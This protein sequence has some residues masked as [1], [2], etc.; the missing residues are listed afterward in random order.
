VDVVEGQAM[1]AAAR[2]HGKVVQVGTQRRSTPHL[3]E[4]K[5]TIIKEG[6]LGRVAHVEIYCYYHMRARTNPPDTNPPEH[7][8][9]EMWTGPA[10]LRPYNELVHPRRWRAFTEYGNGIMGDMCIHML[11]MVR[12]ALDLGWPRRI[13]STG[14][15]LVDTKSKAN[16][17]DTQTATFDYG[18]KSVVWTHRTWGQAPDPQ[19]P[20]GAT[21]YGERGTLKMSVNHF[22]FTPMGK[23]KPVHRE[24]VREED[25]YPEDKTERDL[26]LHVAAA[27]RQHMRDF[28][29]AIADKGRPVADIEQGH[30]STA[31]CI[32]ANLSMGLN[33]SLTW[34][35]E[36]QRVVGDEEANKLLRR[37][38]R[39]P[40]VHPEPA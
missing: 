14:G 16:I 22:D 26:E 24:H 33:R 20:W 17:P 32:L 19:Y 31:C 30:I 12:W 4:A 15:I 40:W 28:L 18:D 8:D 35:S 21:I 38:Y 27:N 39:K 3:V 25:K 6:R 13:S 7:L 9:Y 1:V 29:R 23:D 11:D 34:D 36:K 37:P 10:P 5:N 2:R